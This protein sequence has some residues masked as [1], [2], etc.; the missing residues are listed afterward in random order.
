MD[1]IFDFKIGS[2]N[3]NGL[4][5]K[6]NKIINYMKQ[7]KLTLLAIQETHKLDSNTFTAF[8]NE[9][10][11]FLPNAA[12]M[13]KHDYSGTA[14]IVNNNRNYT[15]L[16]SC[17]IPN[18]MQILTLSSGSLKPQL[19]VINVYAPSDISAKK[20]AFFKTLETVIQE[21]VGDLIILG[22]FN[23]T[24]LKIDNKNGINNSTA[25]KKI[26]I[27]TLSENNLT[28]IFRKL[29]PRKEVYTKETPNYGTR[30]DRIYVSES[31]LRLTEDAYHIYVNFSDH[32]KSPTIRLKVEY[33]QKSSRTK[34]DPKK[35]HWKLNA[36]LLKEKEYTELITNLIS[37]TFENNLNYQDPLQR[38]EIFKNKVKKQ[39]ITYSI[40]KEKNKRKLQNDLEL[41]KNSTENNEK[42]EHLQREID[43]YENQG[44]RIRAKMPQIEQDEEPTKEFFKSEE[45]IQVKNKLDTLQKPNGQLTSDAMEIKNMVKK[46]YDELWGIRHPINLPKL[47]EILTH[48]KSSR[49]PFNVS[50]SQ[51]ISVK[52]VEEALKNTKKEKSP[53]T[54][55][56]PYEYYKHFWSN[57]KYHITDVLNNIFLQNKLTS[58]MEIAL[59]SLIPKKGNLHDLQN[60]R[61]ISLLNSDYKILSKI[62]SS[63]VKNFLKLIISKEQ[64]CG[65]PGRRIE[66][67]HLNIEAVLSESSR[68]E[69]PITLLTIDQSKAFDKVSQTFLFQ[70][71]E[72]LGI[73]E[74]T[75]KWTKILYKNPRSIIQITKS[76]C[77]E[78]VL[79]KSGIRQGCPLSMLLYIIGSE[80][81]NYL[82]K[83]NVEIAPYHLGKESI[84]LQQ[85]ADDTTFILTT[86]EKINSVYKIYETFEKISGQK[87]NRNKTEALATYYEDQLYIENNHPEIKISNNISILGMPFSTNMNENPWA[88]KFFK[89]KSIVQCHESR[90]LTL[91]GKNIIINSLILPHILTLARIYPITKDFKKNIEH[92]LYQFLW[93]PSLVENIKRT[94]LQCIKS[95]GGIGA[96]SLNAIESA[97]LLERL[98]LLTKKLDKDESDFWIKKAKMEL[99]Y[100]IKLLDKK[101]FTNAEKHYPHPNKVYKIITKNLKKVPT[102]YEWKEGSFKSLRKIF[103][104]KQ[105]NN[106]NREC[107]NLE[108]INCSRFYTHSEKEVTL[109]IIHNGYFWGQ[110][111]QRVGFTTMFKNKCNFCKEEPDNL[112]HLFTECVAVKPIWVMLE[113]LLKEFTKQDVNLEQKDLRFLELNNKI[114]NFIIKKFISITRTEIIKKKEYL[115]I[116]DKYAS[117]LDRTI[118]EIKYKIK[119]KM[120]KFFEVY[121]PLISITSEQNDYNQE[122][123]IAWED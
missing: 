76:L 65:I 104:P 117:N 38:W 34:S 68:S 35:S 99:S 67:V 116:K 5:K 78:P 90:N 31:I 3:V 45:H 81:L 95:E 83:I 13:T 30:I 41:K 43:W 123:L 105:D 106:F 85:Y 110:W 24:I 115:E 53:G 93:K 7:H 39:S 103:L 1:P 108:I 73:D 96:I 17:P 16:S 18:R 58:T 75:I 37:K 80:I 60:W 101:L 69:I 9:N 111:R 56:I 77:T 122:D 42:I 20:T 28:D 10:L 8:K 107:K 71:M 4:K 6:K 47:K 12:D 89:I 118:P 27:K 54:D 119:T 97:A 66:E 88:Q 19:T 40:K 23:N 48:F 62:L 49:P 57:L 120:K 74:N 11:E 92:I 22:D 70:S 84:L 51:L 32:K 64:K 100:N 26:L 50:H 114:D 36:S 112:E 82:V 72:A 33:R 44:A 55:G 29:N 98:I 52:E 2:I 91:I 79:I 63:R 94:S 25:D 59:V 61:P 14:F 86:P 87:I 21:I 113:R 102:E 121:N 15:L 46:K 109:R